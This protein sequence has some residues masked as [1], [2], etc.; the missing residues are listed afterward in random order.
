MAAAASAGIDRVVVAAVIRDGKTALLLER[1]PQDYLGGLFELP[2]GLVETGETLSQALCREV[3]EETGLTLSGIDRYLGSFDYH[4]QSGR[5]T[6]QFNFQATPQVTPQGVATVILS[7]HASFAWVG[8]AE[9][10]H[11]PA[12]PE[13]QELLRQVLTG[14]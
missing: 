14:R 11:Y 10:A 4:S 13:I 6:R 7:E 2:G 1:N 5:W 3:A 8:L 9:L 12:S